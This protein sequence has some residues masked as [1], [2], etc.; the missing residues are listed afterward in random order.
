LRYA[1]L[2]VASNEAQKWQF[3]SIFKNLEIDIGF[4]LGPG[5]IRWIFSGK[6][7]KNFQ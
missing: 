4:C 7:E 3:S 6:D 2:H 5:K 1:R